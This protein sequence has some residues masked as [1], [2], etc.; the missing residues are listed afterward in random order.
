MSNYLKIETLNLLSLNEQE[1]I[2]RTRE[3]N[4]IAAIKQ[5]ALQANIDI[6]KARIE[7]AKK[8][9]PNYVE[10][11]ITDDHVQILLKNIINELALLTQKTYKTASAKNTINEIWNNLSANQHSDWLKKVKYRNSGY[12]YKGILNSDFENYLPSFLTNT[13]KKLGSTKINL[14]KSL[15]QISNQ[16]FNEIRDVME[17]EFLIEEVAELK[18]QSIV[19]KVKISKL[20]KDVKANRL[21]PTK[22]DW[23]AVAIEL[24][25]KGYSIDQ[26]IQHVDKGRT[27]VSKAL[28]SVEAKAILNNK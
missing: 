17:K 15:N 13:Y 16:I 20:E 11:K 1:K 10:Q 7:E 4:A 9:D 5:E 22:N 23:K 14:S 12:L 26:I 6:N 27:V 28:N 25:L 3:S 24:R 2:V 21:I 8:N 19:D 18:K